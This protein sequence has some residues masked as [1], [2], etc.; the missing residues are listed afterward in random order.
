MSREP[1]GHPYGGAWVTQSVEHPTLDFSLGHD[2]T[3][4]GIGPHVG[5]CTDSMEPSWD[6]LSPSLSDP[7]P[8]AVSL[9][10]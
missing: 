10:K 6:S 1:E 7:L 3:V 2:L 8:L 5:L 4:L 9:S